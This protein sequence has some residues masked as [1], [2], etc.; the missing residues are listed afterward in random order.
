MALSFVIF[1]AMEKS[2]QGELDELFY[3]QNVHKLKGILIL[4]NTKTKFYY[5]NEL[6]TFPFP[7]NDSFNSYK[8]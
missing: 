2:R 3:F 5:T 4:W 7:K 8:D 1:L 6:F